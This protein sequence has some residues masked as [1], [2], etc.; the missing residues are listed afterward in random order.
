LSIGNAPYSI[1]LP[2]VAGRPETGEGRFFFDE[3]SDPAIF[4]AADFHPAAR[5]ST[6]LPPLVAPVGRR[7]HPSA[8]STLWTFGLETLS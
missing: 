3:K 6:V 2:A 5:G 7:G 8:Q 1:D 4:P